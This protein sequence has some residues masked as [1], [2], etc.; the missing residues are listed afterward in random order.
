MPK[1][2][3]Y[4]KNIDFEDHKFIGTIALRSEEITLPNGSKMALGVDDG[5]WVLV[6]QEKTGAPFQVYECDWPERKIYVDKKPGG[7]QE[8]RTFKKLINYF[9]AETNTEDLV[10]ILPPSSG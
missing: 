10:T 7:P 1:T 4:L 2:L 8:F 3:E 5:H 6:Y 9:F